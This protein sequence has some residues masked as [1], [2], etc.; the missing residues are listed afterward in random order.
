MLKGAETLQ[1]DL[2][3]LGTP[4]LLFVPFTTPFKVKTSNGEQLCGHA[5]LVTRLRCPAARQKSAV[6][7]WKQTRR[8]C[9]C[10]TA[11]RKP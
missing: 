8:A 2:D 10:D 3:V 9:D 4:N 1:A 11:V 7:T 5:M 6:A